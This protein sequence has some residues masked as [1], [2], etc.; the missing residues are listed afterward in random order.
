MLTK[1]DVLAGLKRDEL[2]QAHDAHDLAV[3]DRRSRDLLLD[4]LVRSRKLRLA[5]WL[6]RRPVRRRGSLGLKSSWASGDDRGSGGLLRLS[7]KKSSPFSADE[8]SETVPLR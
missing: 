8:R 7:R 4:A 5:E 1:R 2:L 3:R 6:A